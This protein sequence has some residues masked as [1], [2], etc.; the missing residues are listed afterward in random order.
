MA[1]ASTEIKIKNLMI[2]DLDPS[3]VCVIADLDPS[4]VCVLVSCINFRGDWSVKFDSFH[5]YIRDFSCIGNKT[6]TVNMMSQKDWYEYMHDVTNKFQCV[7]IPYKQREFSMLIIL[8]DD[9]DGLDSVVKSL[10]EN[11]IEKITGFV[12]QN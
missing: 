11:R 8:P 10:S 2:A 7:K 12:Q 4:I 6:T 9:K 1:E 5:T 3:I